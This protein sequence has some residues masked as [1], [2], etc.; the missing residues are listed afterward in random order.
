M[1]RKTERTLHV[2]TERDRWIISFDG[3]EHPQ[4]FTRQDKALERATNMVA[5][6]Q[7]GVTIEQQQLEDGVWKTKKKGIIAAVT[8]GQ[9]RHWYKREANPAALNEVRG[10]CREGP[11]QQTNL[12]AANAAGQVVGFQHFAHYPILPPTFPACDRFDAA[13]ETWTPPAESDVVG[14]AKPTGGILLGS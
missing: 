6:G 14:H 1:P 8:C 3:C 13:S 12:P 11:P 5:K 9:C 4:A 10:D 2:S 7:R